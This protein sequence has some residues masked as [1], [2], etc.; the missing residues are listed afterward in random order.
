[1]NKENAPIRAYRC[2]RVS[3]F[4]LFCKQFVLLSILAMLYLLMVFPTMAAEPDDFLVSN[5]ESSLFVEQAT[6]TPHEKVDFGLEIDAL[7]YIT[8]GYYFSSWVGWQNFRLRGVISN[9]SMPKFVLPND[10]SAWD[11]EVLAIII[12][13]FP[14]KTGKYQGPW[15]GGGYEYWES[16]IEIDDS[17]LS[18]ELSHSILTLGGGYVHK[19]SDHFYLN[20]WGAGHYVLSGKQLTVGGEDYKIPPF[21]AEISLKFGWIF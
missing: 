12:D 21:Q 10:F 16:G 8:G 19:F 15:I 6:N 5:P 3:I 9:I 7:P 2:R 17:R 11:M 20:L 14:W 13:Y 4:T 18:G 1:M